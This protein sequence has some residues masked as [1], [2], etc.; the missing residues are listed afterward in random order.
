MDK[1]ER[2]FKV[3]CDI[4]YAALYGERCAKVYAWWGNLIDAVLAFAMTSAFTSFCIWREYPKTLAGVMLAVSFLQVLFARF[5][6]THRAASIR[7]ATSLLGSLYAEAR[8]RW[9]ALEDCAAYD[10]GKYLE[11][12]EYFDGRQREIVAIAACHVWDSARIAKRVEPIMESQVKF[13]F[14]L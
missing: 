1:R 3:I 14:N 4:K 5:G 2:F 13:D 9:N 12:A 10:E 11:A 7:T 6:L 8:T